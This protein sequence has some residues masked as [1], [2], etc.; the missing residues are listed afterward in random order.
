MQVNQTSP[1]TI[2]GPRNLQSLQ[3]LLSQCQGNDATTQRSLTQL[4][5]L[6]YSLPSL[7]DYQET[8]F[9]NLYQPILTCSTTVKSSAIQKEPEAYV[10]PELSNFSNTEVQLQAAEKTDE[11]SLVES[12]CD[13]RNT[14][15]DVDLDP[16]IGDL[17]TG[18]K[19]QGMFDQMCYLL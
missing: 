8:V 15:K 10:Q 3:Q 16:E 11:A 13:K 17:M 18:K 1:S 2:T 7:S 5:P 19:I 9:S 4:P 14:D 6:F 12:I